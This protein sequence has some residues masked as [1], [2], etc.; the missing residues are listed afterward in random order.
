MAP[1]PLIEKT[2]KPLV[3]YVAERPT[4]PDTLTEEQQSVWKTIVNR[5]PGDWFPAE[6][7][8]MLAAYCTHSVTMTKLNGMIKV[9][10]ELD[11]ETLVLDPDYMKQYKTMVSMRKQETAAMASL[12]T[13]L[14]MTIQSTR[15]ASKSKEVGNVMSITPWDNEE[16][17]Y[18]KEETDEG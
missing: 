2:V 5:L 3:E 14:R 17:D 1:R 6:T 18:Y 9:L 12:A 10:E 11:A 13:K 8:D 15:S 4:P 16:Y 7:H